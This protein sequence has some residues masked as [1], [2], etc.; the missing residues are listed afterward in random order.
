MRRLQRIGGHLK[1]SQTA[2]AV[3]AAGTSAER[4]KVA[5]VTG[6][7]G[8][9]GRAACELLAERC[10]GRCRAKHLPPRVRSV[11]THLFIAIIPAL[12]DRGMRLVCVDIRVRT[13][14]TLDRRDARVNRW[15]S[16]CWDRLPRIFRRNLLKKLHERSMPERILSL[17]DVCGLSAAWERLRGRVIRR[18]VR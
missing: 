12:R 9:I 14:R 6:A 2:S 7:G 1:D 5:V 11:P 8:G 4:P 15:A 3:Q 18:R 13:L 17:T 16:I 10:Q